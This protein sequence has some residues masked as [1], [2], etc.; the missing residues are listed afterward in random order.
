[1]DWIVDFILKFIAVNV[2]VGMC[3][4]ILE[5]IPTSDFQNR[6]KDKFSEWR[7]RKKNKK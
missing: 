6:V 4:S 2:F 1:M 5:A 7:N 3:T